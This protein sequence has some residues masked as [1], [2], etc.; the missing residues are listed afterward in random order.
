MTQEQ[1]NQVMQCAR[2]MTRAWNHQKPDQETAWEIVEEATS[3][4]LRAHAVFTRKGP[5]PVASELFTRYQ[6][7]RA[8]MPEPLAAKLFDFDEK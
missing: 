7:F 2:R 5:T 3:S 6:S 1:A 8:R 4:Y